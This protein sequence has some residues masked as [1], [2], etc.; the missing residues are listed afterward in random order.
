MLTIHPAFLPRIHLLLPLLLLAL[1]GLRAQSA[2]TGAIRGTVVNEATGNYVEGAVVT[3]AGSSR[4][5]ITDSRGLFHFGALPPGEH[6]L[7]ARS[8]GNS[9][10]EATV[11]VAAGLTASVTLRL[12]S[13]LVAMEKLMVTA[14]AEGQAQALNV[15]KNSENIRKVVSQDALAN[16]RLGEVGEVLMALPGLYLEISTHQPSRPNI[17]GLGS[18][19]NSIT[20]DGVRIGNSNNDRA[21]GVSGY[22]AESLA[23]V[24]LMKS[25]TPDMEGD[26]IGGSINLVSRR[27]FDLSERVLKLNLG[28]AY[29]H[30][31]RNWDKQVNLEFADRF[32]RDGRLGV[33]SSLNHYRSD[34]GY[35]TSSISYQVDAA[36][37]FNLSTYT[38]QDRIEDDSWKLKYTGS[39]DYKLSDAITLW[40]R[41]LY[42]NDTR[43]LE[44]YRTIYRPG[45]RTAITPDSATSRN[46]RVDTDRQYREPVSTSGQLAAG[47]ESR[48]DR[49]SLDGRLTYSRTTN[50]YEETFTPVFSFNGTD[51]SYDRRVREF[52]I[53]R[54]D[55]GISLADASRLAHRSIAR[56]QHP[57]RDQEF[58]FDAN[59]R[60]TLDGL[61]FNAYLKT[62]ARLKLRSW[63]YGGD[64]EL[65]NWT[66]TGPRSA[67]D[68]SEVYVNKRF[69]RQSDGRAGMA[70]VYP[71]MSSFLEAFW[72][73]RGEF[74]RDDNASAILIESNRRATTEE[75]SATYLMGGANFGRLN[76]VTGARMEHTGF[77]GKA[78][79]LT[80]P[81]GIL[82]A[83]TVVEN[84]ASYT[85]VLPGLHLNYGLLPNLVLR[86]SANRSVA[87]PS[88]AD[89]LPSRRV[90]DEART[91]TEGNPGLKV[92]ASDNLDLSAEY[93]LKPLGV[94][95]VGVFKKRI[96]GF[97]FSTASTVVGGEY[98]G[99]RLTRTEMGQGGRV[100]GLEVDW[101]QRLTFLPG[102]FS[103]LG[104]G[105]NSTWIDSEGRY[106]NRPGADLTFRGT[107]KRT[108][109]L[110]LSYVRRGFDLRFFYNFRG[111]YLSGVGARPALDVY[112]KERATLDFAA[113]YRFSRRLSAYF[114][115]KNLTDAPKITYQGNRSN[116]TGVRYYDFSLNF[117]VTREF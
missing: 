69:F 76:V 112:E 23:R 8:A 46:G 34:R 97:Y 15:Q 42:S 106:P 70:A 12:G 30:Q 40:L 51:L 10:G 96:D 16:S 1:P 83:S 3:L 50:H 33:Y 66:Y 20:F 56:T 55:N 39:V 7:T 91:L 89:M 48:L 94:F 24:E 79:Q 74:R 108:G 5:E 36:D 64:A 95:S 80:T 26:A 41:G 114:N 87:R 49:W 44:D 31:Q 92:T 32:G 45:T 17:R 72:N 100:A 117:G 73:R 19:F 57:S 75:I 14:Q 105:A 58:T 35:H 104:L 22:P 86:F 18:E 88:P 111:D 81:R 115:A 102:A 78:R 13:E 61:P 63:V 84:S 4:T 38:L 53:F 103:G 9:P 99:Y 77:G 71:K 2:T 90:D 43:Y 25:V 65:G 116:P 29:N 67:A 21:D 11:P 52:P 110:N 28:G 60:R 109:N 107:A 82:V 54:V 37:N 113:K 93:Y 6:R 27:A 59:A 85:N 62:G 98:D 47:F 101:Q 68:L